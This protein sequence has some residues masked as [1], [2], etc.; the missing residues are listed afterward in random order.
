VIPKIVK[1]IFTSSHVFVVN[2][3]LRWETHWC[4]SAIDCRQSNLCCKRSRVAFGAEWTAAG[5]TV[6]GHYECSWTELLTE[7]SSRWL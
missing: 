5:A 2:E 1:T 7:A 3:S 4:Q 6:K